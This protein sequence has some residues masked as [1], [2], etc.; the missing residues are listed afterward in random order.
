MVAA[1]APTLLAIPCC[2]VLTAVKII[3]ETAGIDRFKSKDAYAR[4]HGSAPMPVWSSNKIAPPAQP[5]RRSPAQRGAPPHSD[6][7]G[8]SAPARDPDDERRKAGGD[9]GREAL[10]VLKRRISDVV[11]AALRADSSRNP[12]RQAA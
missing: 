1:A 10:R 11:Y 6:D 9:S 8:A 12:E 5:Y 7:P 3:G 4:H 2:G